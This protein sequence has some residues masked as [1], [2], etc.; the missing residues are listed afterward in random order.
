MTAIACEGL[1]KHYGTVVG[2]HDL[3]LVVAEG[4]IFG[5]LGPNGAGKTTTIRL[6]TGLSRPTSGRAWIGGQEVAADNI[7]MRTRVG[8]LAEEPAFY[9]WMTGEELLVFVGKLFGLRGEELAGRVRDLLDL[10]DLGPATRRRIAGYSRGMRQR[11]GIAQAMINRPDVLLLDEP[12]SALDPAGR[13]DVLEV[14]EQLRGQAT[15]F[16]STHILA[17]VERVCDSVGIIDHGK[18]V[19]QAPIEALRERYAAPIF[20]VEF[21]ASHERVTAL[22][23]GLRERPW[24][25]AV[26]A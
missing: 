12:C 26:E 4:A 24:V 5:F 17:D 11:L 6:L 14:I 8:Y 19:V 16:M 25:A 22:A 1:T 21:E 23:D 2:L 7:T 18:I 15:V 10:A 20:L 13:K 9:G 3:N